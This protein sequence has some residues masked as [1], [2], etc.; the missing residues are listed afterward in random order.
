M[1]VP[2]TLEE[3]IAQACS[4]T[5]SALNDG[6]KKIQIE[7]IYPEIALESQSIAEQLIPTL[8]Q[9]NVPIKVLFPDTGAAALARR[10]WGD[11]PF[12]VSDL[13][14]SRS[15]IEDK[16]DPEDG[17]FL[18]VNPSSIEVAQVDNLC[19]L[20]GDRPVVLLNPRL[21]DVTTIG[22]GYAGRQLRDRFLNTLE[23]CYYFRPLEGAAVLRSYPSP[24]QIWLEKESGYEMIAEQPTKPVGEEL[25]S[26]FMKATSTNS[27][28]SQ[29]IK[30][31]GL[32]TNLQ[33]F[34]RA[35]SQ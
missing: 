4:A 8:E 34:L 25:D 24:W 1:T 9:L 27:D 15:P 18:V 33:R 16:I 22:I 6:Y 14:T 7:F 3:A 12:K 11:V 30:K 2:N 19:Q 23:S 32:F 26:I 5:L 35:L 10:D 31:P 29:P 21:E 13:G 20:A 28:S 17:L